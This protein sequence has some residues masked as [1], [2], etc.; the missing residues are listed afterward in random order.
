MATTNSQA[1]LIQGPQMQQLPARS[2]CYFSSFLIVLLS[3]GIGSSASAKNVTLRDRLDYVVVDA[4]MPSAAITVLKDGE[5]VAAEVIG[6][7]DREN[8]I[9]ATLD[10]S[11]SVASVSKPITAVA[12]MILAERGLIDLDA[13]IN[14]YLGEAKLVAHVGNSDDATVRRVLNHTAGLPGHYHFFYEDEGV[15]PPSMEDSIGQYGKIVTGPGEVQHYSNFGYGV[16]GYVIARVSG[17]PY[18]EFIRDEIFA[19]LG[20]KHSFVPPDQPFPENTAK[21]YW[22]D[23]SLIPFYD[24]DHRGASAIYSSAGDLA[25]FGQFIIAAGKG[26]GIILSSASIKEIYS[27]KYRRNGAKNYYGL[28]LIVRQHAGRNVIFHD[29][30]MPGAS[31]ELFIMPDENLVIASVANGGGHQ[32]SRLRNVALG[33]LAPELSEPSKSSITAISESEGQW[34]G[35]IALSETRS[36]P[37]K[38]RFDAEGK[39]AGWI[40]G[41]MLDLLDAEVDED[42]LLQLSFDGFNIPTAAAERYPH[43]IRFF[44][45]HRSDVLNGYVSAHERPRKGRAGSSLP[46]SVELHRG[47]LKTNSRNPDAD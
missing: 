11:Y 37:V 22:K 3:F 44:L 4:N 47:A 30:N 46:Y 1:G 14:D 45:K 31:A 28:G 38:L 19:P 8:G 10:T 27:E 18:G 6:Y 40:D 13:P 42:G 9:Q 32:V 33:V 2:I 7:A 5:T 26:K 41:K 15:G 43:L 25:R 16:L 24:T 36:I 29:G 17:K 34:T 35:H 21:R 23:G 20:M 39:V 12:I